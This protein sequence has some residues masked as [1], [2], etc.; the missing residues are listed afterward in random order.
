MIRSAEIPPII[1][2][3]GIQITAQQVA[4]LYLEAKENL[5]RFFGKPL[6]PNS[7][8]KVH[9]TNE[10]LD[11]DPETLGEFSRVKNIYLYPDR[12]LKD[13]GHLIRGRLL[14]G[15]TNM[16]LDYPSLEAKQQDAAQLFYVVDKYGFDTAINLARK[17]SLSAK[18]NPETAEF[19]RVAAQSLD[20]DF[21]NTLRITRRQLYDDAQ[22]WYRKFT[23]N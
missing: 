14:F 3:D 18:R 19:Y 7:V 9:F 15:P 2:D 4:D 20:Q 11:E 5:V 13:L 8:K 22:R 16:L 23:G 12:I 1:I 10:P 6:L 17:P 21:Q